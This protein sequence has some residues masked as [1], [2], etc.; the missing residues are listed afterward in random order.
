MSVS[1]LSYVIWAVIG[2]AALGLWGLSYLRPTALAHPADV[3]G[4]L[5]THPVGRVVLVLGFLWLGWHL[6]AR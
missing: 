4:K 5:A 2:A 1:T 3:V 6:F